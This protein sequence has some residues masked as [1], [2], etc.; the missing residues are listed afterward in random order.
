MN[1]SL[2]E[3]ASFRCH[4]NPIKRQKLLNNFH[5]IFE[6]DKK[7]QPNQ[8]FKLINE[9]HLIFLCR[10]MKWF[11]IYHRCHQFPF[12]CVPIFN[13]K[14][15]GSVKNYKDTA[16]GIACRNFNKDGQNGITGNE[17]FE[18]IKAL[19][20]ACK[21]Q[22]RCGQGLLGFTP[23][24]DAITNPK[25]SL[26]LIIFLIEA[27]LAL[28]EGPNISLL[29]K[30]LNGLSPLDHL[31]SSVHRTDD[32]GSLAVEIIRYIVQRC[33]AIDKNN[34]FIN[35]CR[36]VSPL[37]LLLSHKVKPFSSSVK[38]EDNKF[39]QLYGVLG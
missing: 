15:N 28:G 19:Y 10:A 7:R 16:L 24:M 22:I 13:G 9:N 39:T 18:A 11:E 6:F 26:D 4:E 3:V 25:S 30:D 1:V 2:P 21:M 20:F 35:S 34:S 14:L 38:N 17:M 23:L 5:P 31:V 29:R 27:D 33:S 8:R 12:E 37:I 36:G 32:S